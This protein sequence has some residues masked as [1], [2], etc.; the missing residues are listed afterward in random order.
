VYVI[1]LEMTSHH[2]FNHDLDVLVL[3]FSDGR[4]NI[5]F[6]RRE[7]YLKIMPKY[8]SHDVIHSFRKAGKAFY[9]CGSAEEILKKYTKKDVFHTIGL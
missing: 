6:Y 2:E 5:S 1:T 4:P 8:L 3:R 9:V 7:L